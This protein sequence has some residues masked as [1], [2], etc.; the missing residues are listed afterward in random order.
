MY[1]KHTGKNAKLIFQE[2]PNEITSEWACTS[3]SELKLMEYC[4][5]SAE[6]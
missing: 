3:R 4:K 1:I 5:L 6:L 2:K